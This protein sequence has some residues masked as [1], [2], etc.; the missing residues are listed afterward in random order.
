M[1][2]DLFGDWWSY[3]WRF[4]WRPMIVCLVILLDTDD[5]I[6]NFLIFEIMHWSHEILNRNMKSIWNFF[7]INHII[8]VNTFSIYD[9]WVK[10]TSRLL[11]T[12]IFALFEQYTIIIIYA[13]CN[14]IR[15]QILPVVRLVLLPSPFIVNTTLVS[16]CCKYQ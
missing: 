12:S 16:H 15:C 11:I 3:L 4:C 6:Y 14:K 10:T 7:T 2:G 1:H 9:C 8:Q 5:C 13:P